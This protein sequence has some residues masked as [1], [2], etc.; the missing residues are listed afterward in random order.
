MIM[1]WDREK[2]KK[3]ALVKEV[4][5][6]S[7]VVV[8]S[9]NTDMVVRV[10]HIPVPGET[11][12]GGDFIVA[13]GGKGANQAVAAA[14]LGATVF[15]VACLGE[16]TFGDNAIANFRREGIRTD[17]VVRYAEAPSGVALIFVGEE[18][19]NSIAVAPGANE[20]LSQAHLESAKKAIIES[21]VM[22]LELE[23]PLTTVSRAISMACQAGVRVI[24]NPAPARPLSDELLAQVDII[25]PNE[26]EASLLTGVGVTDLP[27]A[28]EAARALLRAGVGTVVITMGKRGALLTRD[29]DMVLV[30]GFAVEAVDTTAAGDAFNGGLAWAWGRGME[31]DKAVR[32]ANA[33]GALAVTKMGAQPS[34]PTFEE[35]KAFLMDKGSSD[36]VSCLQ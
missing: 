3:T 8:G 17:Y 30:P 4:T 13:A 26:S 15:L 35:V 12:L 9:S 36:L 34:L 5:M 22:L 18:G 25:T 27:S 24:L 33:V 6:P 20:H 10:P 21:D 32:F 28:K 16:D 1:E 2:A 19:E 23:V 7:I 11:V 14:R 31:L 29:D